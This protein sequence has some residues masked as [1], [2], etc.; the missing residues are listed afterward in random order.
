MEQEYEEGGKRVNDE[1]DT[2]EEETPEDE[3]VIEASLPGIKA[4]FDFSNLLK[5]PANFSKILADTQRAT[6]V[7][8]D[9]TRIFKQINMSGAVQEAMRATQQVTSMVARWNEVQSGIGKTLAT[10]MQSYQ[11]VLRNVFKDIDFEKLEEEY[12][13]EPFN[14]LTSEYGWPPSDHFPVS[15]PNQIATEAL[16]IEAPD[17]R[18]TYVNEQILGLFRGE[19]LERIYLGWEKQPYLVGSERLE[20]IKAA[21]AAH[22]DGNYALSC[23]AILPQ[24]EGLFLEQVEG[25]KEPGE[26]EG[27]GVSHKD[28]E[29]HLARLKESEAIQ[30]VIRMGQVLYNFV[31]QH[32]LFGKDSKY[33][34]IAYEISRHKILHGRTTAYCKREDISLRHLLWLDCVITLINELNPAEVEELDEYEDPDDDDY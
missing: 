30:M 22:Q 13:L 26:H 10:A 4:A 33:N 31:Q 5:V 6:M 34:P 21:Y 15:V 27:L 18:F 20:I 3:E 29:R 12:L 7:G 23:P 25:V 8:M 19:D 24:I 16:K 1:E 2:P 14:T 28:Y 32:G 9:F 11:Q 17:K